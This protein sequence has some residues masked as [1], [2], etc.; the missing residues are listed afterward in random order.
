MKVTFSRSITILVF[1]EYNLPLIV[2]CFVMK[3]PPTVFT[4]CWYVAW[5]VVEVLC[6]KFKDI[7]HKNDRGETFTNKMVELFKDKDISNEDIIN[8]TQEIKEVIRS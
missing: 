6:I 5:T 2:A 1:I 7:K 3:W 4:I 8:F